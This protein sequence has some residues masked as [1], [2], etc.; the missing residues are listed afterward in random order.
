MGRRERHKKISLDIGS[1][2]SGEKG[3]RAVCCKEH[4]G[5][6]DKEVDGTSL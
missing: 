6:T 3:S 5:K 2:K 1:E 4:L